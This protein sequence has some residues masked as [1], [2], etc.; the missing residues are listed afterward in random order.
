MTR[1]LLRDSA[2]AEHAEQD[3]PKLQQMS[4]YHAQWAA[5]GKLRPQSAWSPYSTRGGKVPTP[6]VPRYDHCGAWLSL[7]ALYGAG[8]PQTLILTLIG[9]MG[10]VFPKSVTTDKEP[11]EQEIRE[12]S[13]LCPPAPHVAPILASTRATNRERSV[14]GLTRA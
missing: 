12:E 1:Q 13:L 5:T 11:D 8:L 2:N 9:C 7:E 3:R 10:Q 14:E 4:G 6:N